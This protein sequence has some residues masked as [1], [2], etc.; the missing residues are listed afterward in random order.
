MPLP[1]ASA[2]L[3]IRV[4]DPAKNMG[5]NEVVFVDTS[6]ADYKTLEAGVREGVGVVEFGGAQNGLAQMARWAQTHGG[7]DAIHILS[8]GAAGQLLLGTNTVSTASLNSNTTQ[9]ELADIGHALKAGGDLLIYGC[10]VA[11]DA[12][13]QRFVANLAT[14]TGA[15]LAASNNPTGSALQGGDWQLESI[16]GAVKTTLAFRDSSLASYGHLLAA[17]GSQV[18]ANFNGKTANVD[19]GSMSTTDN[20]FAFTY[21]GPGAVNLWTTSNGSAGS[22]SINLGGSAGAVDTLTITS[23]T[24]GTTFK[25]SSIYVNGGGFGHGTLTVEGFL[26]GVSAGTQTINTGTDG[27]PGGIN[28]N[29]VLNANTN[30]QNVDTIVISSNATSPQGFNSIDFDDF[31]FDPPVLPPPTATTGSTTGISATGAALHG[32][33]NDNGATTTVTFDYGLTTGY[34]TNVA[35]TTGGTVTAGAGATA[36]AVT[37]SG[38]TCNTTYHFRVKG[39]SASG[40]TNGNDATFT[41]S[42]CV[43]GAPTIGVAT[44]GDAQA[45][46]NFTAPVSNGGAAITTYTATSNPNGITGTCAGPA[47]CAITVAGLS[48]GTAYTFTVTATN[49]AGTGAASAASN[50]VTPK[51][52][53]T[54]TFANPGAQNFGTTPTL[55]ASATS[56]LTVSFSSGTTGVCTITSGGALTFV[57]AGTCT[58]NADQAGDATRAAAATVPQSFTVNAVVPGAPTIGTATAG[59]TQAS[60]TFTAPASNGGATITTYTATANPNGATG[61]CATSPCTV[62]GLT[63]GTAYTF[64]VTA[65]NSAGPGSA[66]A[67]SNSVTP[68]AAQTIT[69]ANPGAQNF[70]TTPTLTATSTSS[71]TVSFTSSTTG[72]CT[73]TSGGA[74]TFVTTGTC[75]INADQAGNGSYLAATQVSRSFTVNAVVPGAPTI[76]TATAGDTQATVTFTAPAF[77]G[78]ATITG[79]TVTSNP[80]GLTGTG[81]ASPI[82]V[83]GL[84]NGT[85]YTF[86]V[87]A[88]NSAGTGSASAASNSVT[89]NPGP[90]VVSVAVP[91]NGTYGLGQN[92]DFT[93]TWDQNIV[94]TGTPQIAIT[95]NTGGTVQ[96]G[97]VSS[98]TATTMLF[99]YTI[100]AGK[101]DPDGITI[102]ALTLNGGTIQ[103]GVGTNATLTLNSV[104]STTSV[105][106]DTTAP[107]LP[108]ANI[109]VNNQSDPHK[110]ILT[111]SKNL[112]ATSLGAAGAWTVTANGGSPSYSVAGVAL[113][114]GKIV[115]LTLNTVDVTNPATTITN[116]AANAHLKVTPLATLKDL[117][118]NAYGA[119]LVTESGATHILDTTPPI[120]SAVATSAPTTSGGTLA[121]TASEKAMGYWIAVASGSA[122]PTVAQTKAGVNYGAVTVVAHGSGALASGTPSSLPLTGLT[123]GTTY[124][125]YVVAEDGAGNPSAAVATAALTTAAPPA[126]TAPI[127]LQLPAPTVPG[128][129]STPLVLDMRSG[130]G[131]AI[132]ACVTDA[133]RQAL[134]GSATYV[135]QSATGATQILWNGRLI[136]FYPL[137][138]SSSDSRGTGIYSQ[139][140]NPLDVVSSCGTLNVTPAVSS[141]NELGT[142]LTSMGLVAQINAQGVITVLV[143]GTYYVVRPDFLI[144]PGAPGAPRLVLGEDGLYRFTDSNGNTQIMRPAVLDPDTLQNQIGLMGGSMQIQTDGTVLLSLGG[145]LYVLTPDLV[146]GGI[147]SEH[148]SDYWWQDGPNHY[149]IRILSPQ[150][151]SFSQ[152]LTLTPRP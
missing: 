96:A 151:V 29:Q 121:A 53:Q 126:P 101:N 17:L 114:S 92:L 57:T 55:T 72:V 95:F 9:A 39:V 106:V 85:S 25:F 16:T 32:T 146:L 35:A 43:P 140:T 15:N 97:Y 48:N 81:A 110:V 83:P 107:T 71:L 93:V 116:A 8:H 144:T 128:I 145:N 54:I 125:T 38:L 99:R 137:T 124:D 109:V 58:I 113:S 139:S 59:D 143:N 11:A 34:G 132:A 36:T 6:V 127:P 62:T 102:G 2:A 21:G 120:L 70:G 65:T 51:A 122:A 138:A 76:G 14:A 45:T 5:Q 111:F 90:A 94:V 86:T 108:A 135:G 3:E 74:L 4:A 77:N 42:A 19:L 63:N 20:N 147:P 123:A 68:K 47:A 13:G 118:G 56:G 131:P 148:A 87:T 37:L 73:V 88:T 10:N 1:T 117:A 89:P 18:T 61:T 141:L 40:T 66:S 82:T 41:T 22:V 44:A 150:Y 33:V 84:L 24:A 30:L 91:A 78:G 46:V 12:E 98:P 69:F 142:V 7:L 31:V 103:N 129:G 136:S 50:S 27:N 104:A 79:Y 67:P 149:R 49:S 52:A 60:V 130:S 28:G 23:T 152:G 134:G 80:G 100:G 64:T 133:V 115:T 75:T 119:G 26:G 105:L 112:D